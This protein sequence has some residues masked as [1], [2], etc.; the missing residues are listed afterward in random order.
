MQVFVLKTKKMLRMFRNKI[1]SKIFCEIFARVSV[2]TCTFS[3]YF[4]K[5]LKLLKYFSHGTKV[6]ILQNHP[7]QALSCFK[8][9]YIHIFIHKTCI[10][11]LTA[12]VGAASQR[13]WEE[14]M[15]LKCELMLL[16]FQINTNTNKNGL[17]LP[18]KCL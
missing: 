1:N 13:Y 12:A 15:L 4:R 9:I 18:T 5:I 14:L 7:F 2:K 16:K 17:L 3:Q 10:K 8:N 11:L 6:F